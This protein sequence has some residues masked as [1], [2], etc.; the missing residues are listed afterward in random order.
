MAL[1]LDHVQAIL[2]IAAAIAAVLAPAALWALKKYFV[3]RSEFDGLGSRVD[4]LT[5]TLSAA[6]EVGDR[7][8]D[9]I[10]ALQREEHARW[11][12]IAEEVVRPLR[13]MS[14]GMQHMQEAQAVQINTL[15]AVC[16]W[17]RGQTPG[18]LIPSPRPKRAGGGR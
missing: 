17:I 3:L 13:S 11:E 5:A 6:R 8:A 12:R 7:N 18:A 14:E 16:E 9:E 10:R 4:A 2:E 1:I 15:E